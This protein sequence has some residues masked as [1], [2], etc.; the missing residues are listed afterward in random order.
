MAAEQLSLG[1]ESEPAYPDLES[2]ETA[3]RAC[4]RCDLAATRHKVVFGEGPVVT[5]MHS[6]I[7]KAEAIGTTPPRMLPLDLMIVGEGPGEDE[8][9]SGRPFVGRSG[10]LL[11]QLL[12]DA[13]LD[14]RRVWLTNAVKCRPSGVENG[15]V[16]NRLPTMQELK[17]CQMWWQTEIELLKP[18]IIL[19]LGSTAGKMLLGSDFLLTQDRGLF[20]KGPVGIGAAVNAGTEVMVTYHPAYLLRVSGQT[21]ADVREAIVGD[22]VA[23]RERIVERARMRR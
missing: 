4:T 8:D 7:K 3:C 2:L 13:G 5:T 12:E 23:I 10:R 19:G 9:A 18:R 21:E 22:L 17:T 14:R 15:R 16:V 1:F 6:A 20:R 11:T